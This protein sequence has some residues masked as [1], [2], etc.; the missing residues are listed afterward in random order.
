MDVAL[1]RLRVYAFRVR[2]WF[3]RRF[4]DPM[5]ERERQ[6]VRIKMK[7]DKVLKDLEHH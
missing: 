2:A 4:A 5:T 6:H 1:L 7:W 3:A